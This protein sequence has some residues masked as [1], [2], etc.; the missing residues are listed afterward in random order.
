LSKRLALILAL[1]EIHVDEKRP[2]PFILTSNTAAAY[3]LILKVTDNI[4]NKKD[5]AT[6][7][8]HSVSITMAKCSYNKQQVLVHYQ[9]PV[10]VTAAKTSKPRPNYEKIVSS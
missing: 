7:R 4:H 5:T 3:L 1:N 6:V 9:G 10:S 8:E 2:L